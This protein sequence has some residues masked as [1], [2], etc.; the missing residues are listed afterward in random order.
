MSTALPASPSDPSP[1]V[2]RA[3]A[4]SAPAHLDGLVA[5][6]GPEAAPEV[7]PLTA[8]TV[9]GELHIG[10]VS[11]PAL[12]AACGTPLYV[13]DEADFRHRARQWRNS[14]ADRV[15]YASKAFLC[16][17]TVRWV[18][19]EG[20]HL[21]VCSYGEFDLAAATGFD[22]ARI[23][24]HGNNK[25]PA[26]LNAA[27]RRGIGV[28]V[29]DSL[30]EIDHLAAAARAAGRVQDVYLRVTPGVEAHTHDYMATGGDDVKFGFPMAEGHAER[31]AL[32]VRDAPS[33]RLAG[34]HSH[35]G[36]QVVDTEGLRL[37]AERV[38][39]FV[40]SL[41]ERHGITVRDLDLGGGAGIAYLP[42]QDRLEPG[43]FVRALRAGV[44]QVMDPDSLHLAVEP[45][46]SVV[47]TAGVTV[48]RV[49]V[50]KEGLRRCFVSVDGGMSDALRP[51]LYLARYTA[52]TANRTLTGERRHSVVVGRHCE[53]GDIVVPDLALPQDIAVGDLLAVPVTGAYHHVMASNYNHQPRPAVV[54]VAD[55]AA[56]LLVHR[57]T[58]A[59]LRRRDAGG[60]AL[61]LTA[62]LPYDNQESRR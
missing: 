23:V 61:D 6:A 21:D 42:G 2:T 51:S 57:E 38:A 46:R 8:R 24:L 43:A 26:E 20:L 34:I 53:S 39:G 7:W 16:A 22:P 56:K 59:D 10:G 5:A 44:G 54:A 1:R 33:L 3:G 13:L 37:A 36:S 30:V 4:D 41:G 50:V 32:A 19:A 29:A 60:Q 25:P 49:G 28:V 47:G 15:H 48:Y 18:D 62:A 31:A 14:G 58:L 27:V 55:G 11:I 35:I 9:A 17:E 52:W 12:A 40:R 45:G